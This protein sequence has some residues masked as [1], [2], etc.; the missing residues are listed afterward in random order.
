M[1]DR[2]SD[3][4]WPQILGRSIKGFAK[5]KRLEEFLLFGQPG[6][7]GKKSILIQEY[8][9]KILDLS[10]TMMLMVIPMGHILEK[11]KDIMLLKG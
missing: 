2:I 8:S 5:G 3:S 11:I 4:Y 10:V 1:Y 7:D 6:K 9:L